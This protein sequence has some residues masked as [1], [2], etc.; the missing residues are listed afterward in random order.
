MPTSPT[1]SSFYLYLS[2]FSFSLIGADRFFRMWKELFI[3]M[4]DYEAFL[5]FSVIIFGLGASI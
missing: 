1:V 4:L 3:S 2:I 5:L